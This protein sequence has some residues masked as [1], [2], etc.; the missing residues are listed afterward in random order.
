MKI[1]KP[2]TQN[3][4]SLN[5]VITTFYFFTSF[6]EGIHLFKEKLEDFCKK[7]N[8][9]GTVL[10]AEEGINGTLSIFKDKINIF[11]SF[12]E[13]Y[14]ELE[15]IIFKESYY[16]SHPFGKLKIRIKKEVVSSGGTQCIYN[17]G[18]YIKPNDWDNFI[19]RPD[20]IN[21]DTRNDFEYIIGTFEG[22]INPQTET[23]REFKDWCEENLKDKNQIIT[24]FCTGGVRCEKSTS[25]LKS[26]GYKN[27]F[28]LEGGIIGY[29]I[30]TQNKNNKWKGDCF[31]FDDRVV[32]NDKL[33]A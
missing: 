8:I 25:W 15:D 13:G 20:V 17:P 16:S 3:M 12:F 18:S 29:F 22:S 33:E 5:V 10:I 31:V 27:V 1:L 30:E 28:H 11:Y 2:D 32:I 26:I 6:K 7:N 23:F 19:S 9:L 4:N 21:I 14:K 24:S